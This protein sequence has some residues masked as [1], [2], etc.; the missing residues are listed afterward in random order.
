MKRTLIA[1]F[2]VLIM[3]MG[4]IPAGVA[5][6]DKNIT[7]TLEFPSWQATEA[8]LCDWWNTAI[9]K[10][11][12]IY[13]NVKINFY[14]V[15]YA[16]YIDTLTTMFAAGTAPH[17]VHL[18]SKNFYQFQDMGWLANMEDLISQSE[19][20]EKWVGAQSDLQVDGDNYG[21][22][23]YAGAFA[24]FYNEAILEEAG[25]AVPTTVEELKEAALKTT[26]KDENGN[27]IYFGLGIDNTTGNAAYTNASHFVIGAGTHWNKEDGA[28]NMKDETLKKAL[29]DYKFFFDNGLTPLG[30]AMTQLRQ[31]FVEGKLAFY[32]DGPFVMPMIASADESIRDSLKM[33][34]VPFEIC[35][36]NTSHS[37]HM[38]TNIS[39]TEKELVWDFYEILMT[40]EMQTLYG[41]LVDCPP[42]KA[43]ALTAELVA[44]KPYLEQLVE[45]GVGSVSM[46]P[47]GMGLYWNEYTTT[48]ANALADL[49][50][51]S[52]NT[53]D[54]ALASLEVEVNDMLGI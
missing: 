53:V 1:L 47:S 43:G 51:D 48:I 2:L 39:E 20:P 8:G 36:S 26:K 30:T 34:R 40:D 33:T 22:L 27:V 46:V 6:V 11:N 14:Q 25:V 50:S 16:N 52:A 10:Y 54:D 21:V 49:V 7:Y 35:A 5:E 3:L 41:K 19:V 44:E 37:V 13:P 9:A 18:P 29:E 17:I 42:P 31:Y 15:P 4:I 12:E 24:M 32:L 23:L 45:Y 38:P 28:P